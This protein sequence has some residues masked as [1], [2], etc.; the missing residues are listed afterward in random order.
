MKRLAALLALA[1]V[2]TACTSADIGANA[3]FE[4]ADGEDVG[5]LSA[6]LIGEDALAMEEPAQLNVAFD[7]VEDRQ[8]IRQASLQLHAS[9]TREAFDEIIRLTE[10]AGGFVA[11]ANVFPFD[12]ENEQPE[13]SL[14][15]R[16]PADQLRATM[17]AIKSSVDEVVSETQS[18]QD[19]TEQF[20]DLEARLTNLQAL[21]VELRALLE[22][23]RKQPDADPDK[24][25][26]V[27]NEVS[28]VRGQIEQIQGQL[29]YLS[30]LTALATLDVHITQTPQAVPIVENPW[31]PSEVGKDA[32][33]NLVSGLQ[34][35]AD[36]AIS[37]AV[38][39][40][41]MLIITLG[42]PIAVGFYIYRR[43]RNRRGPGG[44][45]DPAPAES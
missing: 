29:N 30:D 19:V 16:I 25:L 21:E 22:E 31:S 45:A 23:V 5:D 40:L 39:V 20:V 43:Y 1:L 28:S 9:D 11:H 38:Y 14:T 33:R 36:W 42:I 35:V 37:F 41:P 4:R 2:V 27:F 17:K 15:V 12:G 8:V 32:L 6:P 3:R 18:A 26:R 7:V 13:V 10:M 24:L 44:P 34:S